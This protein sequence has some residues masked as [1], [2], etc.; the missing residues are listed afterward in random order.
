M[1]SIPLGRSSISF[2]RCR[3]LISDRT[4]ERLCI[5]MMGA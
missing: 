4:T 2:G 1:L 3:P 5:I